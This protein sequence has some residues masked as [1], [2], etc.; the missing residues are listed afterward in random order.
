MASTLNTE[1]NNTIARALSSRGNYTSLVRLN[2][3][4]SI[5]D[6]MRHYHYEVRDF[7]FKVDGEKVMMDSKNLIS[8]MV[9]N[10]YINNTF[11][12]IQIKVSIDSTTYYTILEKKDDVVV[13]LNIEKYTRTPGQKVESLKPN[14]EK[15]INVT[16]KLIM[17][18]DNNDLSANVRKVNHEGDITEELSEQANIVEFFLFRKDL[19]TKS[20]RKVNKIFEEATPTDGIAFVVK[21]MGVKDFLM[22]PADNEIDY[23]P[24]II[25]PLKVTDAIKYIDTFYGLYDVGSMM[26]FG[27]DRSYLLK[28]NGKCTAYEEKEKK[29]VKIIVPMAGT[30]AAQEVCSLYRDKNAYV[31]IGDYRTVDFEQ[32]D[33]TGDLLHGADI[34][35][36]DA[37]KEEPGYDGEGKNEIFLVNRGR[38]TNLQ[39]IYHRQKEASHSVV[40][41]EFSDID[42]SALEPN[43]RYTFEFE[44]QLIAKK[45]KNYSYMLVKSE[46]LLM[47]SEADMTAHARCTFM[48]G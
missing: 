17:D 23:S 40:T 25:P 29:E 4:G 38:N 44:D 33:V 28:F 2:T 46:I 18:D 37:S 1:N 24:F 39:N 48:I 19:L 36:I 9:I 41:I 7:Y 21:K 27:V 8:Y 45:Y 15:Y 42:L 3:N 26:Y 34:H 35:I 43:R 16:F 12:I 6:K 32:H 22:S 20:K 14:I 11:P 31:M 30:E 10:D 47:C 13:K 5:A